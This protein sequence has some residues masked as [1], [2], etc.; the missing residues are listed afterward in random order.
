M[1]HWHRVLPG[2]I[3]DV[4]YESVVEDQENWSRKMLSFCGLDWES[5]CLE[6]HKTQ[7]NVRTRSNVQVRQPIYRSSLARWK[8]YEDELQPL[9]DGL[10]GRTSID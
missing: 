10:E 6:F 2:R 5:A 4:A 1:A 8:S 7:R 3:L 9:L